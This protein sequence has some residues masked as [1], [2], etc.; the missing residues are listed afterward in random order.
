M[1]MTQE[2]NQLLWD[3][4]GMRRSVGKPMAEGGCPVSGE[5]I[6]PYIL[7]TWDVDCM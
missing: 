4:S 6:C 2:V 3:L 5:I 1:A 7:D